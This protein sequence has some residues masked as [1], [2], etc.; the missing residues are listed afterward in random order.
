MLTL[1]IKITNSR[2]TSQ[3]ITILLRNPNYHY[4]AQKRRL[5]DSIL[6]QI[7]SLFKITITLSSNLGLVL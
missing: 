6:N 1:R 4:H 5:M 2:E 7:N 3:E